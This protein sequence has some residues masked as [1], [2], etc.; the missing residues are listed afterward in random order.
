M[1]N[2]SL[3]FLGGAGTVTGSRHLLR[4]EARVLVDCG[5]F[6]GLKTLR[7]KNWAAFPVDPTAIDAVVRDE[8]LDLLRASDTIFPR[9]GHSAVSNAPLTAST[10]QQ[11]QVTLA[12]GDT[13]DAG[14]FVLV[15]HIGRWVESVARGCP[16]E[17]QKLFPVIFDPGE[18]IGLARR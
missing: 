14:R 2:A 1:S 3:T 11:A 18:T 8:I 10:T 9:S 4:L 16:D 15:R 12:S 5:L 6:Q 17:D 7:L 13:I